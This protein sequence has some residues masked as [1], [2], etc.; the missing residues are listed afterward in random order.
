MAPFPDP[1]SAPMKRLP[2]RLLAGVRTSDSGY[3]D[4]ED[5]GVSTTG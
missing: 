5:I 4:A 1:V 2:D 3:H